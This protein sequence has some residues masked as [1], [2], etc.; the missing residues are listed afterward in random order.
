MK[1]ELLAYI[2]EISPRLKQMSDFIF[3]NPEIGYEEFKAHKLLCDYLEEQGFTVTRSVSGLD[4]A[5]KAEYKVQGGGPKIGLLCEYD[6]LAGLG[7]GCGHHMQGPSIVG[8]AVTLKKFLTKPAT[9]LVYGTPA[10]ETNSGKLIMAKEGVFDDLDVAFMMHGSDSTT[11]DCKSLALTMFEFNFQGKAAHAAIAP[12]QGISALE[13]VIAFYNGMAYMREHVT[14]DV[15]LH[16]I[17][18]NGGKAPNIVPELASTQWYVRAN[19]RG[20]LDKLIE[21]VHNV[22]KG[23]A[24]QTGTTVDWRVMKSYDNKVN[25][26]SLN[27][28]LLEY[29]HEVGAD[30]ISAPREKTGSTDFSSVTYRVPGACIR[31]KYVDRGVSS[32]SQR[33]IER[34]KSEHAFNAIVWGSKILALTVMKLVNEPERLA[35]IQAEFK[36]IKEELEK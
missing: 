15:R 33:W 31:V 4:T 30:D 6:A 12:D 18:T 1:E 26:P 21:R 5:F 13:G 36:H 28:L 34:G 2:D 19:T 10:E 35:A 17:I 32:H 9:L 16:G 7:H 11:V 29:A 25:T 24:L 8:A 3:D 27:E 20:K 22:A 14:D 23:A